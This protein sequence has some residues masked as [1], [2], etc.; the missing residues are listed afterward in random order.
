MIQ[1]SMSN[2]I[3]N[4][5]TLFRP[6]VAPAEKVSELINQ[7]T[8]QWDMQKLAA[9]FC[10]VDIEYIVQIPFSIWWRLTGFGPMKIQVF[11]T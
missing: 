3:K 9:N 5:T 11:T 4:G 10:Q 6:N 1:V 2:L 7:N 8:N